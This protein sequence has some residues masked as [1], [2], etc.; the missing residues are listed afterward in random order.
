MQPLGSVL[1][2]IGGLLQVLLVPE[3]R[4]ISD[5]TKQCIVAI[6]KVGFYSWYMFL[7]GF[8]MYPYVS[9]FCSIIATAMLYTSGFFY[10]FL[11]FRLPPI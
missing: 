11:E 9:A 5:G 2:V 1:L 6:F 4:P 7:K 10:S 8:L 3:C